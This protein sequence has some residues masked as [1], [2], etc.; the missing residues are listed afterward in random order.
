M[1]VLH[2]TVG[3]PNSWAGGLPKYSFD[4]M[5]EESKLGNDI[6]L[7]YPGEYTLLKKTKITANGVEG[8]KWS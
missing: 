7:L 8:R 6:T 3:L 5:C 2:Y 4:L 1:K